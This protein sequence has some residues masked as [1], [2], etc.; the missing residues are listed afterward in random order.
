MARRADPED[1][2]HAVAL[3]ASTYDKLIE[4]EH[5]RMLAG[6]G[7]T[8]IEQHLRGACA[9]VLATW[10][11]RCSVSINSGMC[12]V[13]VEEEASGDEGAE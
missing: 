6:I 10:L 4:T 3:A 9:N 12:D 1:L 13:E 8:T 7:L 11:I 2:P 5:R